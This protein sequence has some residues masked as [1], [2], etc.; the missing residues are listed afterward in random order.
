MV[1]RMVERS[2]HSGGKY[3]SVHLRFEEDMVAFS[4]CEYDG[5]EEE[6]HEMDIARERSWRG[7]FRRRHRVIKPGANRVD[8]R[9][10]LTPL[11]VGMMLRGMGYD[12][13]TF[14]YVAAGKIYKAQKYMAP[15]KQMFP[16]LQTKN[17]LATPEELAQFMGYSSRLAALDY[18]VCLH[19]EVFVTTQGG[20][21]PHFLMGHRRYIYGGHTKTIKPDKRK[22]TLLLDNP[23]I[24]YNFGSLSCF[25]FIFSCIQMWA[26]GN[27]CR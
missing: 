21:F 4:C 20:N 27:A 14:V 1:N 12:N 25:V 17:T 26:V 2:S 24:R 11:E 22:L 10:P 19:S 13:S 16:R 8:G 18:T 5:G 7:K 9:C 6:K 23:N 3:V 15:L